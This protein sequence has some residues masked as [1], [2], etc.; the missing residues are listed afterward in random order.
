VCFASAIQD[1][2]GIN[3]ALSK[4][5]A[6]IHPFGLMISDAWTTCRT[7]FFHF[8]SQTQLPSNW[9]R[10]MSQALVIILWRWQ[11]S[12]QTYISIY[13]QNPECVI[14]AHW[15]V[16]ILRIY[17]TG[18]LGVLFCPYDWFPPSFLVLGV[19]NSLGTRLPSS[20]DSSRSHI[21]CFSSRWSFL[22]TLYLFVYEARYTFLSTLYYVFCIFSFFRLPSIIFF[23][24]CCHD[25]WCTWVVFQ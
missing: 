18:I 4:P 13:T 24:F 21:C 11:S 25:E 10:F 14:L 3:F 17:A 7:S 20:L 6:S 9:Q 16:R 12:V 15:W 23:Q 19:F 2:D 22:F 1:V 8:N 5:N